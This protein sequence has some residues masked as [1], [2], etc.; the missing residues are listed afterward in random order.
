MRV[1]RPFAPRAQPFHHRHQRLA[2][3]A[4]HSLKSA[5][6]GF[7]RHFEI[8]SLVIISQS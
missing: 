1:R 2:F 6:P 5:I 3:H 7:I 8:S 4:T